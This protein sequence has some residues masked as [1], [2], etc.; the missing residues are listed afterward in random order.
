M[1]VSAKVEK[2][3]QFS[4]KSNDFLRNTIRNI[5]KWNTQQ[6]V[7]ILLCILLI[8]SLFISSSNS[9]MTVHN[10]FCASGIPDCLDSTKTVRFPNNCQIYV[11]R[12]QIFM[13]NSY[14][15]TII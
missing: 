8:I 15:C 5:F 7:D 13:D 4:K 10:A 3:C 12:W 9:E 2:Y 11:Q 6:D 14:I 1:S